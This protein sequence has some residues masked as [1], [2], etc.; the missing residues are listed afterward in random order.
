MIH[1]LRNTPPFI[2][3]GFGITQHTVGVGQIAT[4]W[5]STLYNQDVYNTGLNANGAVITRVSSFEYEVTY[6]TPGTYEIS[7]NVGSNTRKI[8]LQ[9]NTITL[10]VI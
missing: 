6:S 8:S 3:F 5:L 10:T 2:D 1:E 9:S 7:L 4:V